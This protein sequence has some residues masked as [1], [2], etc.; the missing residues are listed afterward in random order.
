MEKLK[1]LI[2]NHSLNLLISVLY[3]YFTIYLLPKYLSGLN[4]IAKEDVKILDTRFSYHTNDVMCLFEKIGKEGRHNLIFF[5]S[6]IDMIYPLIYGLFFF[7]ILN[8]LIKPFS[9]P[10][11]KRLSFII[12]LIMLS[13]YVE[14]LGILSLL[15]E[16][17]LISQESVFLISFITSVK[18]LL[19]GINILVIIG[20]SFIRL[21]NFLFIFSK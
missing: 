9:N 16:Y 5:S 15:H 1:R 4:G 18:W 11:V 21:F 2:S 20:L 7:L 3:F 10:K 13:D 17:P 14:N 19:V 12:V 8:F 6:V